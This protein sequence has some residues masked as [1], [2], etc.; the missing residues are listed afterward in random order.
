MSSI[1][2]RVRSFLRSEASHSTLLIEQNDLSPILPSLLCLRLFLFFSFHLGYTSQTGRPR[3][4]K[5]RKESLTLH[6]DH[7][8]AVRFWLFFIFFYKKK[9]K[10]LCRIMFCCYSGNSPKI[11]RIFLRY[12]IQFGFENPINQQNQSIKDGFVFNCTSCTV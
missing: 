10:K 1:L 5:H 3:T 9:N 8:V 6:C 12:L 11:H 2:L 4:S 7:V